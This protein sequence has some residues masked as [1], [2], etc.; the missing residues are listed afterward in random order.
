MGRS[1]ATVI[2]LV[3]LIAPGT[4]VVIAQ[5]PAEGPVTLELPAW[6]A[7]HWRG[8][9]DG[10]ITEELWL[11][12]A[13][14]LMLGLNREVGRDGRAFFE[15]LRIERTAEGIFYVASPR[16]GEATRFRLVRL[17]DGEALFENQAHDFPQRISYRLTG[18]HTLE[19]T[20]SGEEGGRT[21]SI[22]WSWTRIARVSAA[23]GR[24][25]P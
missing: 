16:G 18:P 4:C 8:G 21:K 13:G 10:R 24:K 23:D 9:E 5:P 17:G 11:S 12:P 6:L 7:G 1:T 20:I 19:V 14:G 3:L 15:Y 25:R 2:T 22:G